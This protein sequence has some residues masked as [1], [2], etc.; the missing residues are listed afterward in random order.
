MVSWI[1]SPQTLIVNELLD[2]PTADHALQLALRCYLLRPPP[3]F[4]REAVF[5]LANLQLKANSTLV[6]NRPITSGGPPRDDMRGHSVW[7]QKVDSDKAK[8]DHQAFYYRF[9]S[10]ASPAKG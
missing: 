3:Y 7:G 2:L 9:A 10:F 8:R 1:I 6:G 5:Y 4:N